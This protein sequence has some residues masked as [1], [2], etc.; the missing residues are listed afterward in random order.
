MSPRVVKF[1]IC[2]MKGA[3]YMVFDYLKDYQTFNTVAEMDEVVAI[4]LE[5]HDLTEAERNVTLRI[6]QSALAYPGA[7]H[8]KAKTIA[9]HVGVST[10]TVYRAVKKLNELGILRIVASTK[11]NGIK[12]ANIYQLLHVPSEMSERVP[13]ENTHDIKVCEDIPANQSISFNLFKTSSLHEIYINRLSQINNWQNTLCEFLQDFPMKDELKEGLHKAILA[14]PIQTM[15]EFT[16]ARDAMLRIIH[17][18]Q[19]GKLTI[20]TTLRAVYKGAY[21]RAVVRP[22]VKEVEM[23]QVKSKRPVPFYDWLTVR[24]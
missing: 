9:D 17:D 23:Q 12:G 7:A 18:V 22:N 10:K 16:I 11:L 5:S 13:T 20:Q 14:T 6:S 24:E 3:I 4:H 1:S 21:E 19:D 15:R 2:I 8:L